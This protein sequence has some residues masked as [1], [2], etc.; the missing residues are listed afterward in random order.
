[1]N[2]VFPALDKWLADHPYLNEVARL[3]LAIE[4]TL[5]SDSSPALPPLEWESLAEDC[6]TG[7]PFFKRRSPDK[8][9][10][11]PAASLLRQLAENLA[12][13]EIPVEMNRIS[14]L[15]DKRFKA[16]PELS[17]LLVGEAFAGG[18]FSLETEDSIPHGSLRFLVWRS[19]E[20]VIR[21]WVAT[22]DGWLKEVSWGQS[23]CPL[24]GS[25]PT[26]AQLVK[27]DKGR[28]RYLS[29]G[30][31]RTRWS[32]RR[33]CCPFCKNENQ[34]KL[35]I[36][37]LPQEENFRIDLCREC[38]GYIKT[39]LNEG[40]EGLLLAD[41]STLHLDVVAAEQGFKRRANSLYEL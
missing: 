27:T 23:R 35:D 15:L 1:M 14:A 30:C 21:P 10:I 41:W 17:S 5:N 37:E 32:Y 7:T 38:E 31:C 16:D 20:K 22:L 4:D 3:Q 6:K 11:K 34:D 25:A 9:I 19:L 24:C 40:D 8:T 2:D 39:Y 12:V 36:F 26:M 28:E 33:T 29:C 13:A 18:E